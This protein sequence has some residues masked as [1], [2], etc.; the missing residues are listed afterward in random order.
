MC[1]ETKVVHGLRRPEEL[2]MTE[3]REYTQYYICPSCHKIY[4]AKISR[5]TTYDD[6]IDRSQE[7]VVFSTNYWCKDCHDYAFEVDALIVNS[8]KMLLDNGINTVSCCSGHPEIFGDTDFVMEGMHC[9][10][11][12]G[13]E[14]PDLYYG[15]CI[16][17]YLDDDTDKNLLD[18]F[19]ELREKYEHHDRIFV[20][21]PDEYSPNWF[22][23]VKVNMSIE[24]YR[25]SS[26]AV[27]EIALEKINQEM[28]HLCSEL[29]HLYATKKAVFGSDNH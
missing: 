11:G 18:A 23:M 22:L 26:K 6:I 13:D 25:K 15:N 27:R 20:I 4:K 17:I 29:V 28:E 12:A 19:S 21:P 5:T 3:K 2:I 9:F 16:A 10:S 24:R 7:G 8:I 1:E 14:N